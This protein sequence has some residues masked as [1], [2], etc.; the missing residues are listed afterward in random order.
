MPFT[1]HDEDWRPFPTNDPEPWQF[2][3]SGL[4]TPYYAGQ[5]TYWNPRPEYNQPQED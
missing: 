5:H 3:S 1:E 4:R 2:Y